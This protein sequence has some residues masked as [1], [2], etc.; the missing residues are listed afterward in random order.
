MLT[1]AEH[2]EPRRPRPI[3]LMDEAPASRGG[4]L[5]VA[6][7]A[8]I[9]ALAVGAF[10]VA[11]Q[12]PELV[13]QLL[14]RPAVDDVPDAAVAPAPEPEAGTLHVQSTPSRAQVFL[15][16][17]RGPTVVR[18]LPTGL[19]HE[20]LVV[21][22]GH[23]PQRAI[24]PADARYE[25]TA[26]GPRYELAAQ[27]GT[28]LAAGETTDSVDL[29]RSLMPASPGTP[30]ELGSVRVITNPPGAKVFMLIGFTPDVSVEN[31]PVGA[32]TELLV[33]LE[34]HRLERVVVGPSDW[35]GEGSHQ[36]AHV[37]TT[38]TELRPRR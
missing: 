26:E 10:Y 4:G 22:D 30:G 37:E 36:Q 18:D 12:R 20:F 17:G 5:W 19:A 8:V 29:G 33:W 15:F 38:L 31:Q 14:G 9:A 11:S 35:Q 7:A 28:A 32:A 34:G 13:D 25:A 23:R 27:V 24:V 3:E 2:E 21:A 1:P 6:L 16:V